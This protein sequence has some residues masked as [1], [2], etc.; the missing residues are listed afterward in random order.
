MLGH[1]LW[2]CPAVGY[3]YSS[4]P[5]A[6]HPHQASREL[7]HQPRR[8]SHLHGWW[9]TSSCSFCLGKFLSQSFHCQWGF[10]NLDE[11]D[12]KIKKAE[13]VWKRAYDQ[14]SWAA[15]DGWNT[16]YEWI[17]ELHKTW[18]T[19]CTMVHM[20]HKLGMS[21]IFRPYW[22]AHDRACLVLL[23]CL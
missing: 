14:V 22:V 3:A 12:E 21:N 16:L 8:S 1:R 15:I 23:L 11:P 10:R 20:S 4:P 9:C 6:C 5:E 17:L 2:Q 7:V 19:S 13:K 18:C